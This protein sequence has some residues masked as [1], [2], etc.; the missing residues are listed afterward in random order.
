[1]FFSFIF[2]PPFE[3]EFEQKEINILVTLANYSHA[4]P[5][6]EDVE[7]QSER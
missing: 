7:K 6:G 4:V 3:N 5:A 2:G 1:M